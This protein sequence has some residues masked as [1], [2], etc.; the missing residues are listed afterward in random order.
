MAAARK[1]LAYLQ[2]GHE[3]ESLIHAARR[4]VFLKGNDAHDYK[5]SSAVLED[6][7]HASPSYRERYLAASM[8]LLPGSS[9]KDNDLVK[10]TRAA[11]A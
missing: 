9:D 8:L 5:F 7:Y 4:L 2:A 6:Y 3:P 10:R 11:L 1:A